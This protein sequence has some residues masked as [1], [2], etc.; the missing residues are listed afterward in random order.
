VLEGAT[1]VAGLSRSLVL[2]GA[3]FDLGGHSFHTPHPV[4]RE[5]ERFC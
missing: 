1:E 3:V 4:V 5:L 2:D